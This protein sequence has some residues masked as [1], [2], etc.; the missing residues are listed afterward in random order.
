M[1]K[2]TQDPVEIPAATT[3]AKKP[4]NVK[5]KAQI[6]A[7]ESSPNWKVHS[8]EGMSPEQINKI[9]TS[10]PKVT[11]PKTTAKPKAESTKNVKGQSKT[12]QPPP[13]KKP[14]GRPSV[15]TPEIAA[16]ICRRM[17]AGESVRKIGED[18]NMPSEGTIR[19]WA[20]DDKEGFFSQ[21]TRAI[22]IRAMRWAEETVE[23]AD[24]GSNDTYID[25]ESGEERINHEIVARSR[26]RVDT[27]KWI[28]S[29]VLPKIYGDKLDVN[30]GVQTENPLASLIQRIAGTGLP[31]V[32][33]PK[34]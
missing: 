21:Y 20:L 31:V 17:A 18:E 11:K 10:K 16:E 33:E 30:H 27:R 2:K 24:D 29:K 25:P 3:T 26:L 6:A 22:Q 7:P 32:K 12:K 28:T 14:H 8:T 4:S 9:V 34:E 1:A 13:P 23:I 5:V 15:Y 19:G